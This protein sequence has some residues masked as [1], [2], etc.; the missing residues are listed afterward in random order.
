MKSQ[1]LSDYKKNPS[2]SLSAWLDTISQKRLEFVDKVY[3]IC[4]RNYTCG[5][6]IIVEC[7][8]PQEVEQKFK[9]LADVKEIVSLSIENALNQR[10]GE[11]SDPELEL[12]KRFDEANWSN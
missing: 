5:G 9:T 1:T 2:P 3:E 7:Y 12:A 4:E 6:S 10:W 11:D 8:N